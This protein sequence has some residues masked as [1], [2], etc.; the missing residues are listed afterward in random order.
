MKRSARVERC[1][2]ARH[3]VRA[4]IFPY[5]DPKLRDRNG[6]AEA[7][8]PRQPV[9]PRRAGDQEGR[10]GRV[11]FICDVAL[12]PFTSH[13]HDGLLQDDVILNDETV[14]ILTQQALVQAEA[15]CDIIAPSDMMDGRASSAIRASLWMMP[16]P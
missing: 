12:D 16:A 13:G 7:T 14:D 10:A 2:Q 4:R 9:R 15:G 3:P 8:Q 6:A 11:G 5:T 1:R